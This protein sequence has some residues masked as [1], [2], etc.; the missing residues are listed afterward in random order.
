[1]ASLDC[2][3]HQPNVLVAEKTNVTYVDVVMLIVSFIFALIVAPHGLWQLLAKT[4][5][6][7]FWPRCCKCGKKLT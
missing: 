5:V 3:C 6:T 7:I 4:F 2:F 1:L